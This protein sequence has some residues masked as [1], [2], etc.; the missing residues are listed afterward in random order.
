MQV[1]RRLYGQQIQKQTGLKFSSK[2]HIT[3]SQPHLTN[4][5]NSRSWDLSPLSRHTTWTIMIG[6]FINWTSVYGTNQAMVQRYLSIP[7]LEQAKKTVWVVLP[8]VVVIITI[9]CGSGLVVYARYDGCG[10]C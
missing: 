2:N 9:L 8:M 3:H 10:G 7:T 4:R 5:I 6:S 1:G